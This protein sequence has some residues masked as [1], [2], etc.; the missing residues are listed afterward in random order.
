MVKA[1]VNNSLRFLRTVSAAGLLSS[2]DAEGIAA[3]TNYLI[4]N[5]RQVTNTTAT[6]EHNRV[7]LKIVTL[8]GNIYGDFFAIRQSHASNFPQCRVRLFRRHRAD[9]Q[10]NPLLLWT[11]VQYRRF[12][13]STFFLA[14]FSNQLI[15]C[16]H[17]GSTGGQGLIREF[18]KYSG[19]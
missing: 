14:V 10:A 18:S 12:A 17:V 2:I 15:N 5:S 16:G 8:A 6:D 4:S 19:K 13:E 11:F 7:L 9:L 3:A 1:L